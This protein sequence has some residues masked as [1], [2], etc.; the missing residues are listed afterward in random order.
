MNTSISFETA[1]GEWLVEIDET[2]VS[3]FSTS[4]AALDRLK[5]LS[6]SEVGAVVVWQ[7]TGARPWWQ[8]FLGL[9]TRELNQRFALRWCGGAAALIFL[10]DDASEYRALDRIIPFR[11]VRMFASG[12]RAE[13]RL[14]HHQR[15]AWRRSA[16]G[17]PFVSSCAVEVG[18]NGFRIGTF[19]ELPLRSA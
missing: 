8:R 9:G 6:A 7:D 3:S 14:P 1:T 10:D 13:N 16:P 18:P 17:R 19:A 15:S 4:A 12:Y 11:Q 5:Q 2:S